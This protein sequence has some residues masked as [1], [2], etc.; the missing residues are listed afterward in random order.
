VIE[1]KAEDGDYEQCF[2][3]LQQAKLNKLPLEDLHRQGT[4]LFLLKQS[5]KMEKIDKVIALFINDTET[6]ANYVHAIVD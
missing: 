1:V 4:I 6:E 3:W 2:E 5:L